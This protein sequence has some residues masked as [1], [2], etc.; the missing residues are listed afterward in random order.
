MPEISVVMPAYNADRFINEAI[1]SVLNQSFENFE[2]IIINDGSADR[3]KEIISSFNDKRIV[4][5]ENDRNKGLAYSFN[6]GIKTARGRYIARM[7]ADDICE[8]ER[9]AKQLNFLEKKLDIG[10]LGSAAVGIDEHG[11]KKH[12]LNRPLTH[13]GI[14]WQSLFSTPVYHPT[15]MARSDIMKEYHYDEHFG[16]SEDYELWSRLLFTTKIK[17]ANLKEPLI[18]YRIF[19]KSFTQT[20]NLDKRLVSAHNTIKNIEQ[21]TH[22]SNAEKN[23]LIS[24]RQEKRL[25]LKNLFSL[26]KLYSRAANIFIKKE[27]VGKQG[28][29]IVYSRFAHLCVF[30]LKY[31]IKYL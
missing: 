2:F 28:A 22:L 23:L 19:N 17:F 1:R 11:K 18:K 6:I 7:D 14:K 13:I 30:L 15:V 26:L 27:S 24:L 10:I 9:F 4:Y 3:T 29:I 20:L 21:Y 5:I 31:W 25:S 8:Q 16:N 12:A